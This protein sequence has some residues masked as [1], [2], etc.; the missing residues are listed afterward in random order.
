FAGRL[1]STLLFAAIVGCAS[2]TSQP[3]S[4]PPTASANASE[5]PPAD[6]RLAKNAPQDRPLSTAGGGTSKL[7]QLIAPLVRQARETYPDAK[8]RFLSGLPPRETFFVA[9]RLSDGADRYEQVFIHVTRISGDVIS[10]SIAS[11]LSIVRSY[12]RGATIQL[13][14]AELLD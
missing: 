2:S 13:Q 12:R 9:T 7:D 10:G 1:G 5:V 3:A 4:P 11:D 8:R 6:Y 14:E